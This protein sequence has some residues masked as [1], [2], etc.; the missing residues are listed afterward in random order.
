MLVVSKPE[1]QK[2]GSQQCIDVFSGSTMVAP[3]LSLKEVVHLS[4]NCFTEFEAE[5]VDELMEEISSDRP[6]DELAVERVV[7]ERL[8]E[9]GEPVIQIMAKFLDRNPRTFKPPVTPIGE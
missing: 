7:T 5:E 9:L 8:N 4:S 3:S 1:I 2:A 6:S